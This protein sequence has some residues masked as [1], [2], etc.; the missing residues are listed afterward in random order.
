[1]SDTMYQGIWLA[2]YGLG[3]VFASLIACAALVKIMQ[4]TM[5][6]KAEPGEEGK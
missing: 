5:I 1:M 6:G 2:I 3:T 4:L